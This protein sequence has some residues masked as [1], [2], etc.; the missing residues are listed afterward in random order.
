VLRDLSANALGSLYMTLGTLAYVV[1]DGLIRL[2]TDEGLDV[3][4][5]T[6]ITGTE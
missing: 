4:Q 1:N 5:G 3:Y 6:R 2:A